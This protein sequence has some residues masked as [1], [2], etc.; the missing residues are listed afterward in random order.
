[1][2][3]T[4]KVEGMHCKSCEVLLS[5]AIN[6]VEGAGNAKADHKTGLISFSYENDSLLPKIFKAIETEGYKV[7][8]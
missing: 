5:D 8:I 3:K 6:D 1:M 4:V 2:D 7:K